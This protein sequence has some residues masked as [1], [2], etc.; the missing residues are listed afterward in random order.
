M[1]RVLEQYRASEPC[2]ASSIARTREYG[3]SERAAAATTI[4]VAYLL[5]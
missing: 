5:A 2:G 4:A 3:A 1:L